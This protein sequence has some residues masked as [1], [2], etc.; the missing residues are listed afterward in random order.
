MSSLFVS[1]VFHVV[2]SIVSSFLNADQ[3]VQWL[4]NTIGLSM[5]RFWAQ[6]WGPFESTILILKLLAKLHKYVHDILKIPPIILRTLSDK[7]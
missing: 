2:P 3:S 5:A 7:I 6:A 4:L 1:L